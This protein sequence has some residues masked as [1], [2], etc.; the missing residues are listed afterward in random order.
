MAIR[1]AQPNASQLCDNL[2]AIMRRERKC[3]V[4][5]TLA[6]RNSATQ[7]SA[8]AASHDGHQG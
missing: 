7:V 8:I 2:V 5:P 3:P 1:L 6:G 4:L